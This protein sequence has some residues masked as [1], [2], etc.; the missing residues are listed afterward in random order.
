MNSL[1]LA[2]FAA[3]CL[4]VLSACGKDEGPETAQGSDNPLLAYVPAGSP[5]LAGNLERTPSGV[6][7]SYLQKFQPVT[8]TLQKELEQARITLQA[9]P[10]A[11]EP[12]RKLLLAVLQELDGKLNRP[13]LESLG[14]DL[15]AWQVV[16]AMGAFPVAR[17]SLGDAATLEATVQRILDRAGIPAP[18]QEFEGNSFWRLAEN[19]NVDVEPDFPLGAY[20]AILDDHIAFSVFPTAAE[21][22]L[23]P[24]FLGT[25]LPPQGDARERLQQLTAKYGYTRYFAGLLDLQKLADEVFEPGSLFARSV[26]PELAS[27]ITSMSSECKSEFREI[28]SHT[29]RMVMGSTELKADAIG[30]QYGI[31]TQPEI[32]KQLMQLVSD[33]P[34][35]DA[36][37][38]RLLEFSFG[39]KVG[40]ARDFLREKAMAIT[41]APYR[42]EHLQTLNERAGEGLAQLEQPMPPLVNNFRG[43]RL[44]L[45]QL[46]M[47]YL[48][49]KSV[50][51]LLALHV[52]QPEMFV[53]MAQMFLPDLSN[54][55]LVKGEAPV[56]LPANLVPMP[57]T[58]AFAA[59]SD[60][61][62]GISVGVD[63]EREL[64][65]F[66]E[67]EASSDGTLLSLN[68]DTAAYMDFT[69]G[70][71][72]SWQSSQAGAV[73]ELAESIQQA[74]KGI[75]N[76]SFLKVKFTADGVVVDSRIT[77]K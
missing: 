21:N 33:L 42:C 48:A 36:L 26:G 38:S 35:A 3:V 5:Y 52:E 2:A 4:F 8:S 53:G 1:R 45:K 74:Y 19:D 23:L 7:D 41:Q 31:E 16:Y 34:L 56:Q 55:K 77:F 70:M 57:D 37:S 68:Y 46:S 39:I 22:D 24:L 64:L 62:I 17:M 43:L 29:P 25:T 65:P 71:D 75:V 13:G 49:P 58:V 73:G 47:E 28:V 30:L 66:L 18:R 50:D 6:V 61:A 59:I 32:A 72:D 12:H 60:N 69:R 54:L 9:S 27:E 67:Q 51:G 63:E 11:D 20:I 40:A 76:R 14:L 15:E 10:E 44:S